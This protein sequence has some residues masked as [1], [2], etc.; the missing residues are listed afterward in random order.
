MILKSEHVL[1]HNG[2]YKYCSLFEFHKSYIY[3]ESEILQWMHIMIPLQI[4]SIRD[5][6]KETVH[7]IS[8][9]EC[10]DAQVHNYV[11]Y[12]GFFGH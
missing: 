12:S 6:A 9:F 8:K 4:S 10:A 11:Q 7:D 1:S 3:S 2:F 5:F